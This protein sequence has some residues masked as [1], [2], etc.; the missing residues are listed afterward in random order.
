MCWTY[1]SPAPKFDFTF[2][3]WLSNFKIL[4]KLLLK[5]HKVIGDLSSRCMSD[6]VTHST[7]SSNLLSFFNIMV[8]IASCLYGC[9]VKWGV[10]IPPSLSS[11][12]RSYRYFGEAFWERMAGILQ[13]L[14]LLLSTQVVFV[15]VTMPVCLTYV[16]CSLNSGPESRDSI[17]LFTCLI[18]L[19]SWKSCF[20]MCH[21][22]LRRSQFLH[23]VRF[24][25]AGGLRRKGVLLYR[26]K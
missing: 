25:E 26:R 17:S 20:L 16:W 3:P 7:G 22:V 24:R 10:C 23:H 11:E 18:T 4:L 2:F 13:W 14:F 5:K 15:A 9:W 21:H 8:L 12:R 1:T 6:A 19:L